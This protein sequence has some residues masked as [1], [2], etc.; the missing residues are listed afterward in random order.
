M[1]YQHFMLRIKSGIEM[2][3]NARISFVK[4]VYLS[5]LL[6]YLKGSKTNKSIFQNEC[7]LN[8]CILHRLLCTTDKVFS[9]L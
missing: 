3:L 5:I 2:E 9:K 4:K 6:I 7:I 8:N 1:T